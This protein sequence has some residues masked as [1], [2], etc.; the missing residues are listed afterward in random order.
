MIV[1][2]LFDTKMSLNFLFSY[3]NKSETVTLKN[4]GNLCLLKAESAQ[5]IIFERGKA[6]KSLLY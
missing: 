5:K 6:P 1:N 2:D 4:N 3:P